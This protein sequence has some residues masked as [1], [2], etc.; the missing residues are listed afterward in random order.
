[1]KYLKV[2]EIMGR[3]RECALSAL[4]LLAILA[5]CAQAALKYDVDAY[6]QDGLV[7]HLDGIRNAGANA[8]HDANA[9]KWVDLSST[10][11]SATLK[12]N[13]VTTYGTSGWTDNGYMFYRNAWF[14]TD[15]AQ[16]FEGDDGDFTIQVVIKNDA[17][18]YFRLVQR[19]IYDREDF[20][21]QMR[22]AQRVRIGRMIY[23]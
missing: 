7:L 17:N 2:A 11:N 10:G 4:M 18:A 14:L 19:M 5:P 23:G 1:M 16:S 20:I 9:E 22:R 13:G 8:P 3:G 15:R 21:P 12:S 6:V